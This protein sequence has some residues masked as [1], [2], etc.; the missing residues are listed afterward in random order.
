MA[1]VRIISTL[2]EP[3]SSTKAPGKDLFPVLGFSFIFSFCE[4]TLLR[5]VVP[6]DDITLRDD[7]LS[8]DELIFLVPPGMAFRFANVATIE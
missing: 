4:E 7:A 2:T 5:A 3:T 6:D 1:L 8:E